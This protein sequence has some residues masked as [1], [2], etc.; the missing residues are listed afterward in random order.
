MS[1]MRSLAHGRSARG[2]VSDEADL[3]IAPLASDP[4]A[5]LIRRLRVVREANTTELVNWVLDADIRRYFDS[6]DHD[7]LLRMLAHRIADPRV[8]RL[9]GQWLRAGLLEGGVYADMVEG[10]PHGRASA[11]LMRES[12]TSYEG[13]VERSTPLLDPAIRQMSESRRTIGGNIVELRRVGKAV[14]VSRTQEMGDNLEPLDI[15]G[16]FSG[17]RVPCFEEQ[18]FAWIAPC[19]ETCEEVGTTRGRPT[20]VRAATRPV[21]ANHL[22]HAF[23]SVCLDSRKAESWRIRRPMRSPEWSWRRRSLAG[24]GHNGR[25]A[26]CLCSRDGTDRACA[27]SARPARRRCRI[28]RAARAA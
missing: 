14:S 2:E 20:S 23:Q 25:A 11:P 9:I 21:G 18:G 28:H 15:A 26:L 19:V 7:W 12:C 27:G 8:L 10:T 3:S 6:V 22:R 5:V 24:S 1:I 4:H 17:F 13:R 16:G